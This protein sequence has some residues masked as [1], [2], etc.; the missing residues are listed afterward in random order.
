MIQPGAWRRLKNTSDA[1]ASSTRNSH[2]R[3]AALRQADDRPCATGDRG[4]PD[5]RR[6]V[7]RTSRAKEQNRRFRPRRAT[8]QVAA[9]DI[10]TTKV[11][12]LIARAGDGEPTRVLGI[13]HHAS[14]GVRH[15]T[16]VDI[17]AAEATIRFTVEAAERMAG[18]NIRGVVV[19]VSTGAPRS[20]LVA[21]EVSVSGHEIGDT[22]LPILDP[23]GFAD[24]ISG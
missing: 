4:Q 18:D 17:D 1:T 16:L 2:S 5:W 24:S 22:D 14:Q 6:R 21:Y 15:G 9:L 12:C 3:S 8:A 13:G 10:G 20:R 7:T 23:A 11:C 19:N